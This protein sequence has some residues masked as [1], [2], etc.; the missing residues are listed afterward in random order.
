MLSESDRVSARQLSPPKLSSETV[1]QSAATMFQHPLRSSSAFPHSSAKVL[2]AVCWTVALLL[3][4]IASP[5]EGF[6]QTCER[7]EL[8]HC[9]EKMVYNHTVSRND[10]FDGEGQQHFQ[11][12]MRNYVALIQAR[13]HEYL[14]TFMCM[15]YVPPCVQKGDLGVVTGVYPCQ[16]MCVA[17]RD[18]CEP[19]M[20]QY[21]R[22][23]WPPEF[24][25]SRLIKRHECFMPKEGQ[26][27][28]TGY[29]IF[30]KIVP[31][32]VINPPQPALSNTTESPLPRLTTGPHADT[33]C[34]AS[35]QARSKDFS[36]GMQERCGVPCRGVYFS[37]FQRETFLPVWTFVWAVICVLS[38]FF[39]LCTYC[40]DRKRFRVAECN[41]VAIAVCYLVIGTLHV[42][43][44]AAR[45]AG[46]SIACD[47]D[48]DRI[49]QKTSTED[50][51][52]TVV[53][54][55]I[56][57]FMMAAFL[58]WIVLTLYWFLNGAL[59]WT[60]ATIDGYSLYFRLFAWIVPGLQ[61]IGLV[62]SQRVDGDQLTG[63][64]FVGHSD[65][66]TG[67]AVL[68]ISPLVLFL[69]VGVLL[70]SAARCGRQSVLV[71]TSTEGTVKEIRFKR[72]QNPHERK[73]V[74]RV[75]LFSIFFA[76]PATLLVVMLIYEA[77]GRQAWERRVL[78]CER[79][80][81]SDGCADGARPHIVL[82]VAKYASFF[83]VGITSGFWVWSKKTVEVWK[84]WIGC[85]RTTV[86]IIDENK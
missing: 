60:F 16:A 19:L 56:Y 25:C 80:R 54:M 53:A 38:C 84:D 29:D 45:E 52:C 15:M 55:F 27:L 79:D 23:P 37:R 86:I 9:K 43:G 46:D 24:N 83:L 4:A 68:L 77:A 72:A 58:N 33:L 63:V 67:L 61:V 39:T 69:A 48:N 59:G 2:V 5:S 6:R 50:A 78:A 74:V 7:L 62:A 3:G 17:V 75:G 35:M 73:L 8:E 36:F 1:L 71:A 10:H 26:L 44:Y 14:F 20:K 85:F 47:S 76:L 11:T 66:S 30:P 34:P 82:F 13:C 22:Q 65:V 12:R 57:Y 51:P 21:A 42:V 40:I 70:L 31:P 18:K 49:F 41:I 28:P 32:A 81:L 64:C